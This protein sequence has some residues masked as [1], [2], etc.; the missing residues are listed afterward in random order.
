MRA[1][2]SPHHDR[3]L[4][5]CLITGH[6]ARL[7]S[8]REYILTKAYLVTPLLVVR[9]IMKNLSLKIANLIGSKWK[10]SVLITSYFLKHM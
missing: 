3:F 5:I 2:V 6:F 8:G 1:P 4:N 10:K 7:L 9:I